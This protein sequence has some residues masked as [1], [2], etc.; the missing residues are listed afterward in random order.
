MHSVSMTDNTCNTERVSKRM[1]GCGRKKWCQRVRER[2]SDRE[3]E[4][5][6]ERERG[7]EQSEIK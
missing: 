7:V 3:S 6:S 4:R 2:G 1:K 5:A